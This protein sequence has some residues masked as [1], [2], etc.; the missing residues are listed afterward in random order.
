MAGAASVFICN[1]APAKKRFR[2]Q[3]LTW[4]EPEGGWMG[5]HWPGLQTQ[6]PQ[7]ENGMPQAYTLKETLRLETARLGS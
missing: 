2:A 1:P 3:L 5:T 4:D 7:L 6:V